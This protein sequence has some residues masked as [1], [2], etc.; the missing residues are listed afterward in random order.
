MAITVKSF[1]IE[2]D[3]LTAKIE[4]NLDEQS[5]KVS[6]LTDV[7]VQPSTFYF[8]NDKWL[9][10]VMRKLYI[11]DSNCVLDSVDEAEIKGTIL[12][13]VPYSVQLSTFGLILK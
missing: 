9:D 4:I 8:D 6:G 1:I 13:M 7:Q 2:K 12:Q 10:N 11:I 3:Y 5:I